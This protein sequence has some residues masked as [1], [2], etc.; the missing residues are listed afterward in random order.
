[1]K[2]VMKIKFMLIFLII[3]IPSL[4]EPANIDTLKEGKRALD[5]GNYQQAK[6]LLSKAYSEL[7]EIGDY[8]L[9]W[10]AKSNFGTENFEEALLDINHL[11]K[12]YPKSILM[13]EA[14]KLEIEIIKKHKTS[15]LKNAYRNYLLDYPDDLSIKFDFAYYLKEQGNQEEAKRIFKEIFLTASSFADRVE[16][17]LSKEDISVDDLLRKSRALISAYQ[18]AKAEKYLREALTRARKNLEDDILQAL[19]YSLF[20]QKRYSES[21]EIYKKIGDPYWRGRSLLRARDFATFE[22]ELKDYIK[23]GDTRIGELMINYANIKRRSGNF[24]EAASILKSVADK[25]PSSKEDALWFLGWNYFMIGKYGEASEIFRKLYGTYGKL[26][27]YYWA[28]RSDEAK[29]VKKTR[30]SSISFRPGEVYSYFLYSRGRLAQIPKPV[31]MKEE[32][33]L[34]KRAEILYQADLRE[35]ALREVKAVFRNIKDESQIPQFSQIL[36]FLGDYPTSI[37]TIAR[38]PKRLDYQELLYPRVY[39]DL[40]DKAAK[41]AA[42]EPALIY[43]VM[44]EESRFD[45]EAISPA[46][47][48]GLMQLMPATGRREGQRIGISVINDSELFDP[49][50]NIMIGTAYLRNLL[51]EFQNIAFAVAAYNAGEKVVRT[52][53]SDGKYKSVDEFMEDIPYSE[54]RAYVQRVLSSYF[55]YLRMEGK[56]STEKISQ[57]IKIGGGKR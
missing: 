19:G 29:G 45:R 5:I 12:S 21:A 43:A 42:V 18:F 34:P 4:T 16:K 51:S 50:K 30:H 25:Y 28:E 33:K 3:I 39:K 8:I 15:D 17:E 38:F 24:S 55:E 36:F 26:R 53:I 54:T 48:L 37:R 56:L 52:W 14:R 44:R 23:S 27:Y 41:R 13:R 40:V 32:I 35:E 2:K 57:I 10:R 22:R 9:L 7:K 11:K 31:S 47:A 46:G 20:M 6:E 1:M 49:E